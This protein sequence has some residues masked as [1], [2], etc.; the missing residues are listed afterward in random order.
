MRLH[1]EPSVIPG[2]SQHDPSH[3]FGDEIADSGVGVVGSYEEQ[4]RLLLILY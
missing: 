3:Q 1:M 4:S 2:H